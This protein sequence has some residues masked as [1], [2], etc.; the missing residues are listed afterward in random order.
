M[1]KS[2]V[3]F[4][5]LFCINSYVVA[6]SN[7]SLTTGEAVLVYSLPKTE[8]S[9]EIEIEKVTQT[10]GEFFRFSE[11]FLAVRDVITT[12]RTFYRL[13]SVRVVPRAVADPAR[14]FSVPFNSRFPMLSHIA[15]NADGLLC[16][17]NVVCDPTDIVPTQTTSLSTPAF[18]APRPLPLT[19]EFMLA[20]SVAR[21]AEGAA[22]Q[23]YRIRES[24]IA[25]LTADLD[26]LPADGQSLSLMLQGLDDL[27]RKLTELFIGSTTTQTQTHIIRLTPTEAVRN[28][29]LFRVSDMAGLVSPN[30]L[31]G[32]PYFINIVPASINTQPA[33]GNRQPAPALVYSILPAATQV[34]IG[35]GTSIFYAE[36]FLMPQFGVT[37]PIP[38]ELLRRSDAQIHIDVN[39]GRLLNVK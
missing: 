24:R 7:F 28:Q 38:E 1:K 36:Q 27:E 6:Q 17:L 4:A 23:I 25:L 12:E 19:E 35:D 2:I 30:D 26:H 37:I 16:G 14:T 18:T 34:T 33:R 31:S 10:P 22:R 39:T 21:M 9:F 8:L 32:T 13:K 15:V 20:G 11:R 3:L 5:V 29:V